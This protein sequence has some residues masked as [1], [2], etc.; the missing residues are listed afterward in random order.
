[1]SIQH[2]FFDL[3]HTLWDFERNSELAFQRIFEERKI[4]VSITDFLKIYK[5]INFKYWKLYR[6]EKVSKEV[7]RYNRLKETFE[8]LTYSISTELIIAISED[9]INFL[10]DYNH[11]FEGT[12]E[13]LD[14]LKE[15]YELHIITNG[16]KE[17]QHL[18]MEKS[19]I[20]KYFTH[21]ITAESIGVKKPDPKIFAYAMKLAKATPNNSVMIGDSYEADV[22]GGLDMGMSAIYCNLEKK[23]NIKGIST[24]QSLIELKQ[25]L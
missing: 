1:M 21:I 12:I 23:E 2:I 13:I 22:I 19:G 17:V 16:F 18:K 5:P 4:P 14:Y 15:K 3:D 6:E 9:Y 25:Y 10:S 8:E 11:L 7:L 24:I 20:K